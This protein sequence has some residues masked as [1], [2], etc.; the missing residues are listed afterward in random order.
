MVVNIQV[1]D[2]G[3]QPT[4][5]TATKMT[6]LRHYLAIVRSEIQRVDD[7]VNNFLMVARPPKLDRQTIKLDQLIDDIIISQQA[8][9]LQSG[10]RINRQYHLNNFDLLIDEQKIQQVSIKYFDQCNTSDAGRWKYHH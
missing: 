10:I 7:L 5:A 6:N 3:A 8:E 4:E 9:A 1:M 2:S